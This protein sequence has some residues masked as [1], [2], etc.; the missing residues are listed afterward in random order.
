MQ[1]LFDRIGFKWF[2]VRWLLFTQTNFQWCDLVIRYN[3]NSNNNNDHF[4]SCKNKNQSFNHHIIEHSWIAYWICCWDRMM[5]SLAKW[6]NYNLP[7]IFSS[8]FDFK[9]FSSLNY[10]CHWAFG[11]LWLISFSIAIDWFWLYCGCCISFGIWI[12]IRWIITVN[13]GPDH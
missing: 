5:A 12:S 11:L 1:K 3:N 6:Q 4:D 8:V 2:L 13:V 7:W 9:W 10:K